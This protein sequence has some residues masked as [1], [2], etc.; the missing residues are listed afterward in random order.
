MNR[1]PRRS[2]PN[3]PCARCP[4]AQTTPPGEFSAQRFESMQACTG[5]AAT[6]GVQAIGSYFACHRSPLHQEFVCPG[7]LMIVGPHHIG[8]R[9]Q[10]AQGQLDPKFVLGERPP[11]WPPLFPSYDAMARQQGYDSTREAPMLNAFSPRP[12]LAA[13]GQRA[14]LRIQQA[15]TAAEVLMTATPGPELAEHEDVLTSTLEQYQELLKVL[16]GPVGDM[17]IWTMHLEQ[18]DLTELGRLTGWDHHSIRDRL[19]REESRHVTSLATRLHRLDSDQAKALVQE[20]VDRMAELLNNL[21]AAELASLD[22]H[23]VDRHQELYAQ[24]CSLPLLERGDPAEGPVPSSDEPNVLSMAELRTW[25]VD[26]AATF[27]PRALIWIRTTPMLA[28]E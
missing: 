27:G 24:L 1:P 8:V 17:L 20:L 21:H 10:T 26:L 16:T 5:D 6:H 23:P 11:E 13:H 22:E 9:L 7:V 25:L 28:S 3:K 15:I 18:R 4:A 19:R 2:V 12:P 14:L